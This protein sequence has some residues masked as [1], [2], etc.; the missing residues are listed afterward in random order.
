MK[1]LSF[2]NLSIREKASLI[3]AFGEYM[4]SVN[5]GAYAVSL[6]AMNSIFVEVYLNPETKQI[7]RITIATSKDLDKFLERIKLL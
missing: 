3:Y 6:Y 1:R 7:D 5:H 4:L 2:E